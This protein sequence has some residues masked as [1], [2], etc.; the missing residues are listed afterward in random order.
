[1]QEKTLERKLREAVKKLGG[2]ALKFSSPYYTG[3][4][5]RLILLPGGKVCFAEIKTTGKKLNDR[6]EAVLAD[7]QKMGFLVTVIDDQPSLDWFLMKLKE[8][9]PD[10]V[11]TL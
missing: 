3:M 8:V 4:P 6:Q 5:D 1:M 11:H 7:L 10:E 2:R 9:M